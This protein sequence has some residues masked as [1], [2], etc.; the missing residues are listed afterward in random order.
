MAH[1]VTGNH[2]TLKRIQRAV[3]IFKPRDN[4]FD[5]MVKILLRHSI[6]LASCCQQR[7]LIHKI[8]QVGA[9]NPGV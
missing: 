3:A 9:V 6:D 8:G 2:L 1:L 5:R 7:R 4:P